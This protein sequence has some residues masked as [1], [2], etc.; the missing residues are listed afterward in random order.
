MTKKEQWATVT[1]ASKR[2]QEDV[3]A[4]S[5][6]PLRNHIIIIMYI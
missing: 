5:S 6:F 1:A 3:F 4:A 2:R